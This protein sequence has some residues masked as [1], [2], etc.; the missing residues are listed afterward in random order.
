MRT[1][2][3]CCHGTRDEVEEG[4][5]TLHLYPREKFRFFEASMSV[6]MAC[7]KITR[8]PTGGFVVKD[9][10]H[11]TVFASTRIDESLM[12]IRGRLEVDPLTQRVNDKLSGPPKS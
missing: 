3:P 7:F 5:M 12:F 4:L 9:G 11:D 8:L 10:F 1:L 6:E 2:V